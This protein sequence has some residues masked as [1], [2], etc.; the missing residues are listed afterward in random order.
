MDRDRFEIYKNTQQESLLRRTVL[1]SAL[2]KPEVRDIP[3]VQEK[4]LY[5]D[6]VDWLA[7]KLSVSFP[8]KAEI[9]MV[10]LS[11][12][13]PKEAQSLVKAVVESYMNEVVFAETEQKR[14]RL[15]ELEKICGDKEQQIRSKREELKGLVASAAG[16]DNPDSMAARQRGVFDELQLYRNQFATASFEVGRVRGELAAQEALFKNVEDSEVP[17]MEI[18]ALVQSDPVAKQLFTELGWKKMDEAY[19]EGMIK[20]GATSAYANRYKDEVDRLQKQY[21]ERVKLAETKA[22][23]K[24]RST[25]QSEILRLRALVQPMEEG[26]RMAAARIAKKEEEARTIGQTSVDIQMI[27][28]QLRNMDQVLGNLVIERERLEVEIKST[29]RIIVS[30]PAE[31][32]PMPSN[33]AGA[34]RIDRPLGGLEPGSPRVGHRPLGHSHPSHQ[35]GSRRV[36]RVAAAGDRLDAAGAHKGNSPVGI[37]VAASSGMAPAVDRIGRRHRRPTVAKG[38]YRAV[39]RDYGVERNRRRR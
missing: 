24:K 16:S 10:S 33:A 31:E 4:T 32:P 11:L 27:Q 19:T 8:G 23:Q 17:Q 2:R 15:D 26:Q 38:R 37:S 14:R 30:E 25:I 3:V 9:M 18:D 5:S 34:T 29:P 12:E 36:A 7:G 6:P 20:P 22:K 28:S 21:D 39:P 1:L 13:N 35:Y